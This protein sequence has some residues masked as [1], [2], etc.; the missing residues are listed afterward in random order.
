MKND[1]ATYLMSILIFFFLQQIT[2]FVESIYIVN[3]LQLQLDARAAAVLF[4]YAPILLLFFRRRVEKAMLVVLGF[5]F[6]LASLTSVW[7]SHGARIYGAGL[8]VSFFLIF[9]GLFFGRPESKRVN[10]IIAVAVA[11]LSAIFFRALGSTL[12]ITVT[13]M[14]RIISIFLGLTGGF[15]LLQTVNQLPSSDVNFAVSHSRAATRYLAAFGL[16]SGLVLI[17][18][19][20]SSP[21][22]ITRWTETDYAS[23]YLFYIPIILVAILCDQVQ[24]KKLSSHKTLVLVW[25][26]LFLLILILAIVRHKIVFPQFPTS[27][28]VF[29]EGAKTPIDIAASFVFLLSPIIFLDIFIFTEK[30]RVHKPSELALPLSLATLFFSL[31]IFM[32]IFTNV[33][34]YVGE[35]SRIFRNRFYLPFLCA[36]A[37]LLLPILFIKDLRPDACPVVSKKLTLALMAIISIITLFVVTKFESGIPTNGENELTVLTYNIQQGVDSEG[38]KNYEKQLEVIRRVQPD[39]ICLQESDVARISGGNSDIVRYFAQKLKY[40]SYYGPKTVTG[41]FGTAILSKYP[42]E[43][44]YTFFTY[45][46]TDEIGT[47]VCDIRFSNQT[48]TLINNHPAGGAEAKLAHVEALLDLATDH[49]HIVAAGDFN[50]RPDSPY[51][52]QI[53]NVLVDS[54]RAR[55][56]INSEAEDMAD[57]I[58]YIFVSNNFEVRDSACLPPPDSYSDHP[59]FWTRLK[60]VD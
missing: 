21:T 59:V 48:V 52:E 23:A 45:S 19:V 57:R 54:W 53:V 10:W 44:C 37:G 47:T 33:W 3:L 9:L 14:T 55:P 2:L 1:A 41:T 18:F 5:L 20:L 42:L 13:G 25:N 34:G 36:G 32:L 51:Y 4:L 29:V 7:M 15:L 16:I 56:S 49:A 26:F 46:D 38:C 8:A 22:V 6:L 39:V 31:L 43:R 30:L 50:F 27:S 35:V 60:L 17:Y 58:D 24:V 28:P 11:V 12:D 40:H